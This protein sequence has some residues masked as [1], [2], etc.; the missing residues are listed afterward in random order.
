MKRATTTTTATTTDKNGRKQN[1]TEN[2]NERRILFEYPALGFYET[3]FYFVFNF[4]TIIYAWYQV[5]CASRDYEWDGGWSMYDY[6]TIPFLGR[7]KKDIT[8]YE[9]RMY[10][11]YAAKILPWLAGH[12]VLFNVSEKFLS[13][14]V[15]SVCMLIYWL[16]ACLY[17]YE[18]ILLIATLICAITVYTVMR[19]TKNKIAIWTVSLV[20]LYVT[21]NNPS[22]I[23]RPIN[24]YSTIAFLCYK[25]L[26]YISF[27]IEECDSPR[28]ENGTFLKGFYNMFWYAFYLPYL[29]GLIV[30]YRN[31]P[32]QI[33]QRPNRNRDFK[34]TLWFGFRILFWYLFIEFILH[35]L[36][37]NAIMSDPD[38][39]Y[40]LSK[41]TLVT[42]GYA[43]GAMFQLK[44]VIIFGMPTFFAKL[45]KMQPLDTPTCINRITLYSKIWRNFD[46]GLYLFF[47]EYIFLPICRP[48]FSLPRKIFGV[49][50]SYGFVLMWHGFQRHYVIW[51]LLNIAEI[52][53]ETIAKVLYTVPSIRAWRESHL[54][55]RNFRRILAFVQLCPFAFGLYAIFYFLSDAEVGYVF[56]DQIF[57]KETVTLRWPFF[58]LLAVGYPF[59]HVCIDVDRWMNAR[60]EK[61]VD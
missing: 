23:P 54:S 26:Q 1:S 21:L 45:D 61:K 59:S 52:F 28:A 9:W 51:I 4:L 31:F 17:M 27:S 2:K 7:R 38:Y 33:E 3:T 18:W 43:A 10:I 5:Y 8:N 34:K 12:S 25:L 30:L 56:V 32:N 44:Y 20:M 53:M 42:I 22:Y 49:F 6:S 39:L 24:Y 55:D 37:F 14:T 40:L 48:T 46:R 16:S 47:K 57:W 36:Y 13:Q 29:N 41:D 15:W 19:L 11:P 60:K 58:L 35:I 50:V